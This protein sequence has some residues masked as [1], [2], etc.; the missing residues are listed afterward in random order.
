MNSLASFSN[1]F[2]AFLQPLSG[3]NVAQLNSIVAQLPAF[4]QSSSNALVSLGTTAD[5]ARTALTSSAS[6]IA[7]TKT[8]STQAVPFASNF[9]SLFGSFR[10]TGG[11]EFLMQTVYF[12]SAATNGYNQYGHYL[13]GE[14]VSSPG[15]CVLPQNY[16]EA[17]SYD[18]CAANFDADL[19][20]SASL[21][22]R[23]AAM[24][25]AL[26][27]L[28]G[29]SHGRIRPAAPKPQ[30]TP[31]TQPVRTANSGKTNK[32]NGAHS[33]QTTNGNSKAALL[34]YLLGG[35]KR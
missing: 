21:K 8:L 22:K 3:S 33:G 20:T 2:G 6:Q 5:A 25:A 32:A 9:G 34:D 24:A 23:R 4:T 35:G 11:W 26:K 7:K 28:T 18:Q 19:V 12:L 29:P 10:S 17:G 30:G 16:R 1:A 15:S 27:D 14:L 13:R 31:S